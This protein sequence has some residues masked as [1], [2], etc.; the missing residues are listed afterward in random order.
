MQ[1]I[2]ESILPIFLIVAC[3]SVLRR[4]PV[5]DAGLWPG[6]EK[7][8]FYVLFPSYLF[9]TLATADYSSIDIGPI[10][11]VYLGAVLL[12]AALLLA[13]WPLFR[14]RGVG[15]AELHRSSRQRH[16]GTVLSRSPSPRE[17]PTSLASR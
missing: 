6:L 9:T 12:M 4:M 7:L 16:A 11:L 8:G 5:F 10:T 17:S 15:G 3:G 1:V 2:F 14:T 13:T